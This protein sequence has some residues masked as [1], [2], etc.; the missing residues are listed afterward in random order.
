MQA[1]GKMVR[2]H[3]GGDARLLPKTSWR[4]TWRWPMHLNRTC[5]S[6]PAAKSAFPIFCC[7]N[8]P[9]PN[10]ISPTPTGRTF[11][12]AALD[13]AIESYQ[14]TRT[15]LRPH[16]RPTDP[17]KTTLMLKTRV[18]TALILLAIL[19]PVL[20][21]TN[22]FCR[23][24]VVTACF[25]AP[26]IWESFRL[27]NRQRASRWFARVVWTAHFCLHRSSSPSLRG[28]ANLVLALR[29]DLGDAFRAVA[30]IGTAAVAAAPA[31]RLAQR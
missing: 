14:Q 2:Q 13:L 11:D 29:R 18:L 15:P 22:P 28:R 25:S 23:S 3:P 8:W 12:A 6:A 1:I 26:R 7:G 19:L 21:F 31:T 9:I 10:C 5:S 4:R 20:Y 30:R 17:N 16:Q 27:F 24:H